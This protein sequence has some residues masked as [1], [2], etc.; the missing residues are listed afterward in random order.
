MEFPI[1]NN[2]M[3]RVFSAY[4]SDYPTAIARIQGNKDNPSIKGEVLFYQLN[5]G[6]YIKAYII[7]IPL[8]NSNGEP[9][10]FHEFHIH[11]IGDCSTGT[12]KDPFPSTG[13]HFNPDNKQHPFHVGDLPPILSAN[14]IG[15]LSTFTNSFRVIDI[16]ERSIILHE[17]PDDFTSQPSDMSGNK[18]ACGV[19]FPYHY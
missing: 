18:I 4:N 9:T 19:I 11:E 6:V 14:G 2:D 5:D 15:I 10:R 12:S 1:I 3:T 13:E 17:N 16:I 7:G 8:T